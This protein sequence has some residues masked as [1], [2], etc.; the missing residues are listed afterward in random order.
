MKKSLVHRFIPNS[1]PGVRE[2]MLKVTGYNNVDEI[3]EEIP[4]ALRFKG[5][6]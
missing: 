1:A 6:L 2:E 4:P 3:Y 5:D